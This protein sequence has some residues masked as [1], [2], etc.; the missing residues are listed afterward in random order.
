MGG[1]LDGGR[2][3]CIHV[4]VHGGEDDWMNGFWVNGQMMSVAFAVLKL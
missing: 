4:W 2:E 1:R 3:E